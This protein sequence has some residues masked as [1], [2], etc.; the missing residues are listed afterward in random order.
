MGVR[1]TLVPMPHS[2]GRIYGECDRLRVV[3]LEPVAVPYALGEE[4]EDIVSAG[5]GRTERRRFRAPESHRKN[6][7]RRDGYHY[8][9]GIS[10]NEAQ[11]DA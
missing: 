6:K 4:E 2:R 10:S 1:V 5:S 11:V 8:P 3:I 7:G 9:A